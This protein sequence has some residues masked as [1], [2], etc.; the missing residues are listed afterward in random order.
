MVAHDYQTK[1]DGQVYSLLLP[2]HE[3]FE[4]YGITGVEGDQD[5]DLKE[6]FVKT[7]GGDDPDHL[8]AVA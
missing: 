3:T 7:M 2:T 4:R 8:F 5:Q 6:H 1:D